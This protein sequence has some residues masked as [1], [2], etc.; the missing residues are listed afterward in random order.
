MRSDLESIPVAVKLAKKTV[1]VLHQNIVIAVGTVLLL[2]VGLFAG[3][4]HMA[5]GMFI[6]EASILVV[7]LNAMR[8]LYRTKKS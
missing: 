5:S 2:L 6:H 4:I 1:G 3:Y 8:L 7:I